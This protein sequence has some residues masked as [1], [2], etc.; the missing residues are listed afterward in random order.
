[1]CYIDYTRDRAQLEV[2]VRCDAT[3]LLLRA[4]VSTSANRLVYCTAILQQIYTT[5]CNHVTNT[6]I[7]VLSSDGHFVN[8]H[9]FDYIIDDRHRIVI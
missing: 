4:E 1:M 8:V 3:R 7:V 2:R 5:E 9:L 6:D